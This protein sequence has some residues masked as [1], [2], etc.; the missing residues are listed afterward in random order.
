MLMQPVRVSRLT[1]GLSILSALILSLS[2]GTVRSQVPQ[3][4]AAAMLLNSARKAYNEQNYPF[5]AKQF[6]EFTQKFGGHPDINAARY[7]LALSLL[8]G[9]ERNFEKAA[10]ALGPMV[11][12]TAIPE[13]PLA[14]YFMGQSQR[15]MGMTELQLA[16]TKQPNEQQPIRDRANARFNE[17]ARYFGL[18]VTSFSSKLP[19]VETAPKDLPPEAD[20]AARS[21]ADQAEMELRLNRL[22]EARA[23]TEPFLKDV[24]LQ[25]SKY[26]QL[27]LYYQG[28]AAFLMQDY[29]VAGRTL[30]QLAPFSDPVFGL[31]ARYLMGRVYQ[32]SAEQAEAATMYDGVLTEFD[33][34]K[35][36]AIELLKD[37]NRF[38]NNP[39]EKHR[40]EALV[41]TPPDYVAGSVFYSAALQYEAAKFGEALTRFQAFVKD[42]PTSPLQP[43]AALRIGFC[44]VQLKQY[45]DAVNTLTPMVDKNP[46]LAD[47]ILLWLGKAQVGVALALDPMNVQ[48]RENGLK[49]AINTL[50]TASERAGQMQGTDPDA[51]IRRGEMLLE[52]ADTHQLVKMYRE[53]AAI[54]EQVINEKILPGR[55]D[56][57][58]QRLISALQLA[59]DFDRCD[60]LSASFMR[61]NAQSPLMSVVS[62]RF[63]ENAY[64]RALSA[65]KRSDFPN[66]A[67]E[68]PKLFE[69][70]IKRYKMVIE[71]Y[72]EFDRLSLARYGLAMSHFHKG[73]FEEAQKALE[74]IPGPDRNG[75][76][77][78]TP[79]L[80][81]DCLIRSAPAKADDALAVGMLQEKLQ[82]A[83]GY[84]ESFIAAYP[85]APETPDAML[86]LGYCQMRVAVLQAMPQDRA[87]ALANAR[88]T[89]ETLIQMFAKEPQGIQAVL[90]RAK[91]IAYQ[92]DK[93]GAINELRRFTQ[94]PLQQ[95][96]QVATIALLQLAT[97][98]R[99]QNKAE[100]A[101]KILADA[102]QRHEP[103]L[104][105]KDNERI[106][107]LRYHQG[108]CLQEA[109]KPAEARAQLDSIAPLVPGKPLAAEAWLRS[110]QC[111][112]AEGR[113]AIETARQNLAKPNQKPEEINAANN[114]LN[115]AFGILSEA[116]QNL[117]QRAEEFKAALPGAE[118]RAR[119]YYEAAW[120][121]RAVADH[122]IAATRARMQL[123]KQKVLQTE[124]E[125]KA[126]P[127]SKVP[128]VPL[129]EI[130]RVTIPVQ[131][132][133]A[134][135]RA[136]Y[137][138]LI[139]QIS[140]LLISVEARFELAEM[141]A[142]R[143]END[144]AIKLL[145]DAIDKEPSDKQPS[146]ELTDKMRV[147]LGACLAAKKQ[148]RDA[149]EK[150]EAVAN[151]P[152]STLI[153]QAQYRLGECH[154]E[155]GENDKAI[156]RLVVF[157]DKGEFQNVPGISDRALLR[158][159]YALGLAKQWEPSRQTMEVLVG[160][161]GGS[162]WVNEARFGMGWALQNAGQFDPAVNAYNQVVA[163]T[164][165]ELAAKAHL[166][167][168]LCRMAQ[169]K[170]SD[171]VS[172]LLVV[173]F[174][175]D[176]PE[177]SAAALTE[178]ARALSEDKKPEQAD[179]LLRRVIKDYPQSEWAKVAQK[180]LDEMK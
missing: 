107:L 38:K 80:L 18:A 15:G 4:Q 105:N 171:A 141:L 34:Q 138:S 130:P 47:Q 56:E 96:T 86:K 129:P 173:P 165:N 102:R 152:K 35:K 62:F 95:N 179:R 139:T 135:C 99:E 121:W 93:N 87:N 44:Q 146:Q 42:F 137:E 169:K 22:K 6:L 88:K 161:F 148:Y 106:A 124:A 61:D 69:E 157:R 73:E 114:A 48:G 39:T 150:L 27:G 45:P 89:Y 122:E 33:K 158:L 19:K 156:A 17:A 159:G 36:E 92:G 53:A 64:F 120:A 168:G 9:P 134:K 70:A 58:N 81:A 67:V 30:N 163:A 16:A 177:L 23:T 50:K 113:K 54:Y 131:P 84:L 77:G 128:A 90:E 83:Q 101:A 162:P 7:G 123:E 110:G 108:V 147:R 43:E 145:K 14:V 71:K 104:N 78:Y 68:L 40:L 125:K 100:E 176:F 21:R 8:D 111:R 178:A 112:I 140:D 174:T 79:Y 51:K 46:K 52:A 160:R 32:I 151:N 91:C 103:A 118:V 49:A 136:V 175:F 167:I 85:K 13:Y 20:W 155:L 142:E 11:G 24:L 166:Q 41:K 65:E 2:V 170:Y 60:Q 119:M 72:P 109:N 74:A 132:A 172:S 94:D 98:L 63:A 149:I 25:K 127:G 31:H 3:D 82:N 10:E 115:Q 57:L 117:H 180:K 5:A 143:D 59:G 144:P 55:L 29:L 75:D 116:A 66:K 126:A 133:E 76:L 164:T 28:Y 37:P 1:Y 154:L 153:P 26:R 97:F 12:N